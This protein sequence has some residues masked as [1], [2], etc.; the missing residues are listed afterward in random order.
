MNAIDT[1]AISDQKATITPDEIETLRRAR[2]A[3]SANIGVYIGGLLIAGSFA[4]L[5]G[6]IMHSIV[7]GG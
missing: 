2:F 4:F 3:N 6:R 1:T 7:F 5:P